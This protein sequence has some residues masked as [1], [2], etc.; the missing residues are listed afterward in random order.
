[1]CL[2]VQILSLFLQQVSEVC[3]VCVGSM[4]LCGRLRAAS[5]YEYV[6]ACSEENGLIVLLS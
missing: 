4:H 3:I 2:Y 1:M 5:R 6:H